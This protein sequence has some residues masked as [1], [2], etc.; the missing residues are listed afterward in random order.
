ML[1]IYFVI[2]VD[3]RAYPRIKNTESFLT[4]EGARAYIKV[5]ENKGCDCRLYEG[6]CLYGNKM[7]L[8]SRFRY[9]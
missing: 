1:P 4:K 7:E 6:R 5:W 3:N 8:T 2:N 9:H